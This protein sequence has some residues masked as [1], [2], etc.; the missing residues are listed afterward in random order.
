MKIAVVFGG[1]SEER[2]VSVASAAQVLRALRD[3]GHEAVAVDTALGVLGPEAEARLLESRVKPLPPGTSELGLMRAGVSGLLDT[4]C[5]AGVDAVFLAL[6]G[7]AGED[8]TLQTL[9]D[10]TGIPYTGSD[11]RGSAIAMDKDTTKRLLLSAGVQT[12]DWLMASCS[13]DDVEARLGMPVIVKP[14]KQGSTVG[15]SLVKEAA[16]LK[17]AVSEAFR[18]DDEVMSEAFVAGREFTVGILEDRAL[19]VG[20]I[21][22]AGEVFDYAS[23]YQPGGAEELFPA[24]LSPAETRMVQ[25]LAL[26][27]HRA[28]KLRDYSRVDFR[29][30]ADGKFWCLELNSLPGLTPTSLF[31]QSAAAAGIGFPELCERLCL[32]AVRRG[33][34]PSGRE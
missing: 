10:L 34:P 32:L 17:E 33:R 28:C 24:P 26:R 14:N 20:E 5:L 23:K 16:A 1:N 18:H 25:E 7:G 6:H 21:R 3:R 31:P 9:L 30:D 27:A 19:A 29:L 15:L 12:P 2:D 8:G 11:H 22:L 13:P 4:P